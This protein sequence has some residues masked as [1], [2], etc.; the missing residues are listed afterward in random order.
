M[1]AR[2]S[3][4]T[5][6]S[7]H[8]MHASAPRA[9][10]YRRKTEAIMGYP[11]NRDVD[12][13]CSRESITHHPYENRPIPHIY[14]EEKNSSVKMEREGFGNKNRQH[15]FLPYFDVPQ[16][17]LDLSTLS[18]P[19][20][21]PTPPRRSRVTETR[22]ARGRSEVHN[23]SSLYLLCLIAVT[24]D[25]DHMPTV[26]LPYSLLISLKLSRHRRPITSS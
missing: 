9:T 6:C 23:K 12:L 8:R 1:V 7:C 25:T 11:H 19:L 13:Q 3:S 4:T 2:H 18:P 26:D 16:P 22:A 20:Y 14:G 24:H 15:C 21:L 10:C 5:T 17:R